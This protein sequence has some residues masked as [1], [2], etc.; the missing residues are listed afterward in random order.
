MGP[1]AEVGKTNREK[2]TFPIPYPHSPYL[3]SPPLYSPAPCIESDRDPIIH[4]K[5]IQNF[6]TVLEKYLCSMNDC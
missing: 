3:Y 1:D 5:F 6:C 2:L 4:T